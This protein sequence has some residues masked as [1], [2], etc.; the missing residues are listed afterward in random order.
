MNKKLSVLA[1]AG[2]LA[3]LD[4]AAAEAATLWRGIAVITARTQTAACIAEYDVGESNIVEYRPNL[5]AS[6]SETLMAMG[7]HGAF[8]ISS[9][10]TDADK[11]L[12]NGGVS[13]AGAAY[14]E[15]FQTVVASQPLT[16]APASITAAT[17]VISISGTLKNLGITGCNVTF[18]AS[19]LPIFDGPQ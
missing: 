9:L 1:I 8:L 2:L 15:G 16:I 11:T 17:V 7:E 19:L 6:V 5:G 3:G 18:K 13:I 10:G 4:A 14:A 12:R